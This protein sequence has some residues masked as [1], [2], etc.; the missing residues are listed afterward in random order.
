MIPKTT[1][2]SSK[3]RSPRRLKIAPGGPVA[4]KREF[5]LVVEDFHFGELILDVLN[6][7]ENDVLLVCSPADERAFLPDFETT[8][9]D[10]VQ[11]ADAKPGADGS[12]TRCHETEVFG[13]RA[14][15]P[16]SIRAWLP[17]ACQWIGSFQFYDEDDEDKSVLAC[18][19]HNACDVIIPKESPARPLG[20]V[21]FSGYIAL[22]P[23]RCLRLAHERGEDAI[24]FVIAHELV[25]AIDMLRIL[26]PAVQDW[27]TFWS[28]AL[29]EGTRSDSTVWF[30]KAH[31]MILDQYQMAPEYLSLVAIWGKERT[32]VWWKAYTGEAPPVQDA[33]RAQA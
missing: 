6:S 8:P 28:Q 7:I 30:F 16:I 26:V 21:G 27:E 9:A 3:V 31:A 4:L 23:R 19:T 13:R 25:H 17:V 12:T 29:N 10:V 18:Y 14:N 2:D 15:T 24:R 1:S 22:A 20:P 32:D 33:S 11:D 5:K